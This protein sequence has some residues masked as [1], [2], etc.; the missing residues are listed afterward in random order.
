MSAIPPQN[1]TAPSRVYKWLI[2]I[3]T[4]LSVTTEV[5]ILLQ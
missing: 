3:E 2:D 1:T 4:N 5:L